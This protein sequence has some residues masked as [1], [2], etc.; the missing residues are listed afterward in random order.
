[1]DIID[2]TLSGQSR[3]NNKQ[4]PHVIN[5]AARRKPLAPGRECAAVRAARPRTHLIR[6]QRVK[7]RVGEQ[8]ERL[9][10]TP[11]EIPARATRRRHLPDLRRDQPQP[12]GVK[13]PA[14]RRGTAASPYQLI[15]T[16][17]ASSPRSQRQSPLRAR[18]GVEHDIGVCSQA[19]RN[20][21]PRRISRQGTPRF[22]RARGGCRQPSRPRREVP[23]K[24]RDQQTDDP[25]ADHDDLVDRP[26]ARIPQRIERVSILAA[27]VARR[28]EYFR[29]RAAACRAER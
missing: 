1:M 16:I 3:H 14:E 12:L 4:F 18:T 29:G 11:R 26:R 5:I 21:R 22:S 15:S 27:S 25:G 7:T 8:F 24:R 19:R 13:R 2:K 10:E 6:D 20:R 17:F 23:R 9:V 28:E